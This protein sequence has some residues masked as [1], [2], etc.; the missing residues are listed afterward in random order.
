MH[1]MSPTTMPLPLFKPMAQSRHGVVQ[2]MEA[3]RPLVVATLRFIQLRL[4]LPPLKP[5]GQSWRGVIQVLEAQ[6]RPLVVAI[7]RFTQ[8]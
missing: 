4:P 3:Q 6:V 7:P 5:M 8:L 2:V 1:Q